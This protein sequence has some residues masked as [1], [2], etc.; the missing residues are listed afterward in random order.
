VLIVCSQTGTVLEAEHCALLNPAELT[1]EARD[2]WL[3]LFVL[4]AVR[5]VKEADGNDNTVASFSALYGEPVLDVV[6]QRQEQEHLAG[7]YKMVADDV[8]KELAER[9]LRSGDLTWGNCIPFSPLALRELLINIVE[10]DEHDERLWT[11]DETYM[12]IYF[13]AQF[14][15][16]EW[17][18]KVGEIALSGDEAWRNY[19][20]SVIEA[21]RNVY[22][23]T[24]K[25]KEATP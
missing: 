19:K 5:F 17:L 18:A 3:C 11:T 23:T 25:D 9:H 13:G 6:K 20:S 8:R 2:E 4:D 16:N 24:I 10:E 15:D 7:S 14:A 12:A 21:V 1:P 22:V